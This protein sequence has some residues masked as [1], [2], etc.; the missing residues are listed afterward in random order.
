MAYLKSFLPQL[1]VWG[2]A[3]IGNLDLAQEICWEWASSQGLFRNEKNIKVKSLVPKNMER[4]PWR[5]HLGLHLLPEV[6]KVVWRS[7]STLVF[8]N[9]RAQCEIWF[10]R[11]LDAHPDW[12]GQMAMHHGSMNKETR[13]W[14]EEALRNDALK[15]VVCTSSLDLGVDFSPVESCIQVGSPKGVALYNELVAVVTNSAPPVQFIFTHHAMELS[16]P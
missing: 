2:L 13:L 7:R 8:T 9:T 11:L 1:Q 6:V 3:T 10:Q 5:G 4:F 12:A 15:L 14:V 16:K